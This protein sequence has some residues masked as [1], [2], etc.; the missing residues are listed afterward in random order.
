MQAYLENSLSAAD[1]DAFRAWL[2]E[3]PAHVKRL[4]GE[5]FLDSHLYDLLGEQ[6]FR[7]DFLAMALDAPALRDHSP[8]PHGAMRGARALP[9]VPAPPPAT[10]PP[11]YGAAAAGAGLSGHFAAFDR[12]HAGG[13]G[14]HVAGHGILSL[15]TLGVMVLVVLAVRGV[16]VTVEPRKWPRPRMSLPRTSDHRP[17]S[18]PLRWPA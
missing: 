4:V 12:R 5:A 10:L 11:A 1:A 17:P 6:R 8:Y 15:M 3:D 2:A 16:H 9:L 14:P 7:E 13:R 18:T